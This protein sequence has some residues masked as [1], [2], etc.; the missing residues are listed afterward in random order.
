MAYNGPAET[1]PEL[2]KNG[3]PGHS[4]SRILFSECDTNSKADKPWTLISGSSWNLECWFLWRE[5]NR[6]T[7]EK[8]PWSRDENQQ[9]TQPT[10]DAGSGRG[11]ASAFTPA[12]SLLPYSPTPYS[13]QGRRL[14]LAASDLDLLWIDYFDGGYFHIRRVGATAN[15]A[16]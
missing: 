13:P 9:H 5:E 4:R 1:F 11:E 15:V 2:S 8:N 10:C 12:P 7:L 3:L 16:Q 6:R 14:C